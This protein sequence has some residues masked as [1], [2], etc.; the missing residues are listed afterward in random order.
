[1]SV[2]FSAT[3][4]LEKT[5]VLV[6]P[7][8]EKK[9]AEA[10]FAYPLE[11]ETESFCHQKFK[12]E[13]F[14]GK[15]HETL[16]LLDVPHFK[17]TRILFI[18]AG[19]EKSF[20]LKGLK[21]LIKKA[22]SLIKHY[23]QATFALPHLPPYFAVRISTE[24]VID[25][26]YQF[27]HYQSEENAAKAPALKKVH[28]L[29]SAVEEAT[30]GLTHGKI[31][32][33]ATRYV[34]DLGN[35]PG[36]EMTPAH[37]VEEA[38]RL[39]KKSKKISLKVLD[40][41]E[42]LK[43]KM[44]GLL[45]VGKGSANPPRMIL[46]NYKGGKKTDPHL[47]L[48]G[49]GITFD[50]GGISLKP[51]DHMWDMKMDML[52]AGTLLGVLQAAVE[53]NLPLNFSVTLAAAENMPSGQAYKPGDVVRTYSG[54]TIEV[55][56]TDAEGRVVLSDA[57]TYAQELYRP[58]RLIDLATLTGACITALG[59]EYTGA[60][61]NHQ[62]TCDEILAAGKEALDEAWQ[63]PIN[64][65]F[66]KLVKSSIADLANIGPKGQAGTIIGA[67][68]IEAFVDKNVHWVHLDIAGTAMGKEA[69]GRPV[70]MMVQYL[71]NQLKK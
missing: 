33:E 67:A 41:K 46:L 66:R 71:L 62:P 65:N 60:I 52:G 70:A 10:Y 23:S 37:L 43:R 58:E 35:T 55:L 47:A 12:Q 38:K 49:K 34:K 45:S 7:V 53:L 20:D 9:K 8:F 5:D 39:A 29:T 57:I 54:K 30:E 4:T 48:V 42:L 21:T 16:M 26:L 3:A 25:G 56:N 44:L 28:F 27:S 36:N 24:A 61:T 64:D 32:G 19:D 11:K 2:T 6:L 63:L 59:H 17:S 51:G 14:S 13:Q 50:S 15:I 22:T 68:F 69:S 31:I 18:G 40:E 1:M